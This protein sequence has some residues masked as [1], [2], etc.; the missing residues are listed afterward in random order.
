MISDSFLLPTL[1]DMLFVVVSVEMSNHTLRASKCRLA[2]VKKLSIP[3]LE[4]KVCLLLSRL[5][6]SVK[7]A[8][9]RKVA[10]GK[11]FCRTDPQI[12]LS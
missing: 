1:Q 6:L 5:M 3:W 8:V 11:S 12:A 9:E 4:S 7:L 2:P 10:V